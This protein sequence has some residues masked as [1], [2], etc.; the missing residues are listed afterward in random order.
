M[1]RGVWSSAARRESA[2]H[3]AGAHRTFYLMRP[4]GRPSIWPLTG[5]R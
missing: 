4:S 3:R 2:G 1:S 5:T